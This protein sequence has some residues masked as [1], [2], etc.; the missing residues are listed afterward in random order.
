MVAAQRKRYESQLRQAQARSTRLLVLD[1]AGRLFAERGYVATSIDEIARAAGVGRATV[2]ASVGGKPVLLK[3]AY[4]VSLVG[5]DEAVSLVERP[6]SQAILAE[7]D[8]WRLLARYAELVTEI[9]GR[10]A[11][12]YEAVRGAS[13]SDPEARALWADIL[14]QRRTGMDNLMR[15]LMAKGPLRK[16][17]DPRRAADLAWVLVDPGLYHMLVNQ[18]RWTPKRYQAWLTETLQS[19]LLPPRRDGRGPRGRNAGS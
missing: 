10:I 15:G 19:Q 14:Q 2:F 18:R 5:D 4:D 7:P 11:G 12:I 17:L 6:R 13:G 3:Q 16:G 9:A 8:P 1:A